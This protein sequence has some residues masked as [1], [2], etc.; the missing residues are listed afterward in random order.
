[1]DKR[2]IIKII[3]ENIRLERLRRRLSQEKLSEM[4]GI[5]SKYLNMIENGRVNPSVVIVYKI[6]KALDVD[7]KTILGS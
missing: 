6:C 7:A 3:A 2:D 1:M 4:T 5:T